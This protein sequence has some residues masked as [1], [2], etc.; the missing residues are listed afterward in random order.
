MA[1]TR[2]EVA[3]HVPQEGMVP[4]RLHGGPWDGKEVSVRDPQAPLIQV[5]GP[6]KGRH[7][8]WITHLYQ[9][10]GDRYE[11]LSTEVIPLSASISLGRRD[12]A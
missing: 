2:A 3:S 11:F 1:A 10:R 4:V 9:R 5:Y 12:L 6:R 8:L 7:T